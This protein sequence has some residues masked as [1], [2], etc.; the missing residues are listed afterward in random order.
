M[1]LPELD[2]LSFVSKRTEVEESLSVVIGYPEL[3]DRV[4]VLGSGLDPLS[5]E[6][7]KYHLILKA[8]ESATGEVEIFFEKRNENGDLEFHIHGLKEGEIAITHIP[9]SLYESIHTEVA[10]HPEDE[11]QSCLAVGPY[12]SVHNI[13]IEEKP[14]E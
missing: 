4:A 11:P 10:A 7:L 8:R 3:A 6:T 13:L 1:L 9:Y 12:I 2:R 14:N 5:V